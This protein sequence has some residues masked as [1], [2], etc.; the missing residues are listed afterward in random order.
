METIKGTV[1]DIFGNILDLNRIP[2]PI[3]KDTNT[4][5]EISTNKVKAFSTIK[6]PERK[7]L[8]FH[9]EI[10]TKKDLNQKSSNNISTLDLLNINSNSDNSRLRSRFFIDIDK[11][12]QFKINV[13]ASSEK[14]NIPLLTRYENRSS[15]DT[16]DNNNP[17]KLLFDNNNL[18]IFLDSFATGKVSLGE[19]DFI[20]S[21]E[22]GSINIQ[23]NKSEAAP[24]D[25]ITNAHIKHGTA[26]HDILNT[27][28]TLQTDKF[29]NYQV[30]TN[31]NITVDISKIPLL[32]NVVSNVIKVSGDGNF[33]NGGPNAGGRSG[34]INFDGMLEFNIG[35]NTV[36]RQSLWMDLA[37]GSILNLGRD[38]NMRSAVIAADG[39]VIMQVGGMGIEGDSRFIKQNG[40]YGAVFDLR[41]TTKGG[42]THMFRCDSN[43][44]TIMS[45]GNVAI[46]A[47]GNL[48]LSSDSNIEMDAESVIIQQRLVN[49][50]FGGS[51]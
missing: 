45:P 31:K 30:G 19:K 51:I 13:P 39:D 18:D 44:V 36:D 7:S 43:G 5:K 17:N 28:W 26:H 11:E 33:D 16:E 49:K 38:K 29:I 21:K 15:Y 8:A 27:A 34:S 23:D 12:G 24:I 3:G 2:L 1:V 25:R 50:V 41:V 20:Y 9:F 14:G 46:H 40:F 47:A 32:E 10:N 42:Y 37:G 35:A 6:E 4:L 22:K 48:K